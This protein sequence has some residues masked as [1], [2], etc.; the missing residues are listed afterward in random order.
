M[1]RRSILRILAGAGLSRALTAGARTAGPGPDLNRLTPKPPLGWASYDGY[2]ASGNVQD[3]FANLKVLASRLK[4]SGYEYFIVDELLW[5]N[6]VPAPGATA[7]APKDK[8]GRYLCDLDAYGLPL[9]MKSSF[10]DGVE[11]LVRRVHQEGLKFGVWMMRGIRRDAVARNLPIQGT[12]YR[13]QD[14]ANTVDVCAWSDWNYGVDMRKPGAQEYYDGML[15]M[16]AGMGVDFLKYD[17]I[18]PFPREIEAVLK[19]IGK[20][21][22]DIVLSLSPGDE[23]QTADLPV[24]RKTN[25]LRITGDVWDKRESIDK[26]FVR[27]EQAQ[28]WGAPGFWIDLDMIPFGALERNSEGRFRPDKFTLDQ[29]WTFLT[30]RALAASPLIMGGDLPN[31]PE[32]DLALLTNREMLACNQNGVV[33][34]LFSRRGAIDVWRTPQPAT[35]DAGWIGVFNRGERAAEVCLGFK[36]VGLDDARQY[37]LRD[38]WRERDIP[39][40][41]Q[42]CFDLPPDGVAFLRYDSA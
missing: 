42:M 20:C 2:S 19:A 15:R 3:M 26:S 18:V 13:A 14:I 37:Q 30:Q 29:K 38:I 23:I 6:R 25:L 12:R 24:Y 22:R 41:G 32:R 9:P 33:G 11:E 7:D 36:E 34:R 27:W 5:A 21:G 16:L 39:A 4:P 1:H 17:D 35:P 31:T 10:P 40:G 28:D 8:Y